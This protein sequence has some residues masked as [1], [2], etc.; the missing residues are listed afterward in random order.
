MGETKIKKELRINFK[1]FFSSAGLWMLGI[2]LN[3]LPL[4]YKVWNEW[5]STSEEIDCLLLFWSDTDFLCI[6]FSVAFLLFLELFFLKSDKKKTMHILGGI[7]IFVT[8]L[9]IIAYTVA[10][11]SPGWSA[12]MSAE[13]MKTVNFYTLLLIVGLGIIYFMISATEIRRK[14]V[15]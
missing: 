13:F 15:S 5:L 7:L 9:L 6:N 8:F 12:R 1:H 14:V 3:M 11:F 4:V 10:C 2:L